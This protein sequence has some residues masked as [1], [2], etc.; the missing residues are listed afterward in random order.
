[1]SGKENILYQLANIIAEKSMDIERMPFG[2][3]D[4][5]ICFFNAESAVKIK[6]E[7]LSSKKPCSSILVTG[8]WP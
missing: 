7:E 1:M 5:N 3:I 8:G 2:L 4:Y 6:M